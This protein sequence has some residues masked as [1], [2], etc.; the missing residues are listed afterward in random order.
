MVIVVEGLIEERL[1]SPT[2]AL[3]VEVGGLRIVYNSHY[4]RLEARVLVHI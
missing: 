1:T 3:Q 2:R 4:N